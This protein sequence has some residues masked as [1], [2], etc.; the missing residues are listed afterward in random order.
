[1]ISKTELENL[2]FKTH[3]ATSIIREAKQKM[4]NN[5][6][7]NYELSYAEFMKSTYIPHYQASV[8]KSTWNSRECGLYQISDYFKDTKLRDIN[9]R[10]CE[11][12]RIWLLNSSGYSQGYASLLYGMFRK[13]LDYAVTLQYLNEN[14]SK[15]TKAISKGKQALNTGLKK[16]LKKYYLSSALMISMNI[17][18]L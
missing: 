7:A 14:I 6:Y 11:N 9:V 15:R 8:Q 1:M 2:G 4:V 16:N 10:D 18:V 13:S 3:Q 17:C 12:Y 5:G